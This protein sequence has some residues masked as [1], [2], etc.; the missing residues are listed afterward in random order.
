MA[1]TCMAARL[2]LVQSRLWP[3]TP[4]QVIVHGQD[5]ISGPGDAQN[6]A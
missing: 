3:K 1:H 4:R 5:R 2:A 6:T